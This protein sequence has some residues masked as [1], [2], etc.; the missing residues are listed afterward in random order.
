[1]KSTY[2]IL[3]AAI[4]MSGGAP[5][6]MGCA[7]LPGV[8]QRGLEQASKLPGDVGQAASLLQSLLGK[9][10]NPV[11]GFEY[12]E[13]YWHRDAD[14]PWRKIDAELEKRKY[15][16]SRELLQSVPR[17]GIDIIEPVHPSERQGPVAQRDR[18][19]QE[20]L[21]RALRLLEA[22]RSE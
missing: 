8:G 19:Y 7:S 21:Q 20:T 14:G 18:E 16:A 3:T 11:E 22:G 10:V 13:E 17:G 5:F 6:M 15:Y 9:P 12:W 2:A 4:L 1:M